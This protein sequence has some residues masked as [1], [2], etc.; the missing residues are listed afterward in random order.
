[1]QDPTI[2]MG[3]YLASPGISSAQGPLSRGGD[4]DLLAIDSGS[5]WVRSI[6]KA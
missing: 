2:P 5:T 4:D 3:G 1:M 6:S